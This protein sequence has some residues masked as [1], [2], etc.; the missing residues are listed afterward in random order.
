METTGFFTTRG[1]KEL[2]QS[3]NGSWVKRDENF[4][5]NPRKINEMVEIRLGT[6][7]P[8]IYGKIVAVHEYANK[9][10]YDILVAYDNPNGWYTVKLYNIDQCLIF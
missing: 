5:E 1:A 7:Y 3:L 9:F 2:L 10:K 8:P 6:I 4:A